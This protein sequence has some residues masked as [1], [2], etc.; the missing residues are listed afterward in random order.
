MLLLDVDVQLKGIQCARFQPQ[1]LHLPALSQELAVLDP[2]LQSLKERLLSPEDT[3]KDNAL[4]VPL[5]QPPLQNSL[6][7]FNHHSIN[8]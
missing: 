8:D 6:S 2:G 5:Q 7:P 3:L 4:L 1:G